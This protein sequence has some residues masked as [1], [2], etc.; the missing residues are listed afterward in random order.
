VAKG[1]ATLSGESRRIQRKEGH[2]RDEK[3]C[4]AHQSQF[5]VKSLG[6]FRQFGDGSGG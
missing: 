3:L 5:S 1:I 2:R 6:V 4:V